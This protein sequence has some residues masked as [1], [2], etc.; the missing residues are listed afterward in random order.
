[1]AAGKT[2]R[3]LGRRLPKI[4]P[5]TVCDSVLGKVAFAEGGNLLGGWMLGESPPL[6]TSRLCGRHLALG[7]RCYPRGLRSKGE[8]G[9]L[10]D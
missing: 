1:M 8:A 7:P 6:R 2:L 9:Q 10:Q 5:W 4:L 3:P